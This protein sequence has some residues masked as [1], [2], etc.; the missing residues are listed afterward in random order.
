MLMG[1]EA[2]LHIQASEAEEF[3]RT[4]GVTTAITPETA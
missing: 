3:C 2:G 4:S 1:C